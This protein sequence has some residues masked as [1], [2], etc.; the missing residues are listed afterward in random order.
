LDVGCLKFCLVFGGSYLL[1]KIFVPSNYPL[2]QL[3]CREVK[4]G[5]EGVTMEHVLYSLRELSALFIQG[6][7]GLVVTR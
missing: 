5:F 3:R 6:D 2:F 1:V 7:S 4:N